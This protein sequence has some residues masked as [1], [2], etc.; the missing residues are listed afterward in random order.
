MESESDRAA[1]FRVAIFT[2]VEPRILRRLIDEI[3]RAVP[4]ARIC[5][6]LYH[7]L[8]PLSGRERVRELIRNLR[9]PEYA[10]YV[11]V[12]VVRSARAAARWLG[13]AGLKF[14]HAYFPP[15][16]R[17]R[18]GLAELV[19]HCRAGGVPVRVTTDVHAEDALKFVHGLRSDLAIVYGTPILKPRL[20][21]IL[22]LGSINIHQRKVPDYRGGGPIGLWELL[23]DQPEIGVTVH[24]VAKKV[25]TGAIIRSGIIPIEPFDTLDSLALKAHVVGIDLLARAVADFARGEVRETPQVG[26]SRSFRSPKPSEMLRYEKQLA[27]R[28]QSY[29]PEG[30]RSTRNLLARTL[31]LM[32][33]A[34]L[35]NWR[36]RL[37]GSFP[38]VV[39]YHHLVADRLHFLGI[40]TT[41]LVEHIEFL[42]RYYRVVDLETATKLLRSGRVTA[43]TVV[44]TF[45][46]GYGDN[47]LRLRAAALAADIP[48]TLFV[49]SQRIDAHQAFD[50]D[51]ERGYHGFLP[52]T[53]DEARELEH[54]GFRIESHTRTHFDCDSTD[55]ALLHDEIVCSKSEIE[56]H[57]GHPCEAFSFPF[58]QPANISRPALELARS[59]YSCVSSAYGGV[60]RPGQAESRW[61]LFRCPHPN[62]L[63]E[64]ELLLQSILDLGQPP[65]WLGGQKDVTPPR[66]TESPPRTK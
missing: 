10:R 61:H 52:L 66:V 49:C 18:F 46:D 54:W 19:E 17:E 57:L 12:R 45:D 51:L 2:G 26:P 40:P 35:R 47:Y 62:S 3:H 43:P 42:R 23:D 32:P 1:P 4:E 31:L 55:P 20:F 34:A 6:V 44:L 56:Q 11:A 39:L 9:D 30:G 21:E 25:D 65:L 8:R 27:A 13:C 53:W 63:W 41:K 28:R 24:R 5:G 22:R 64:L 36:R 29:V 7:T 58:G 38:I 50:H 33:L 60:N 37:T 48:A 16:D 14:L 59:T 15:G